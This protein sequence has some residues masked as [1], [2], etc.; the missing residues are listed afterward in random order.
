MKWLGNL[1][2]NN[3]VEQARKGLDRRIRSRVDPEDIVQDA[4]LRLCQEGTDQRLA[5]EEEFDRHAQQKIKDCSIDAHRAHQRCARR[6]KSREQPFPDWSEAQLLLG[7]FIGS[8]PSAAAIRKE[9]DDEM[10]KILEGLPDGDREILLM[11]LHDELSYK[12]IGSRLGIKENTSAQ[13]Y[14]RAVS[15]AAKA[16]RALHEDEPSE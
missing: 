4:Y 12:E 15:R 10:W 1:S 5:S 11:R 3:L 13:R 16:R 8:T 9:D 7:L 14:H 6:A 2:W